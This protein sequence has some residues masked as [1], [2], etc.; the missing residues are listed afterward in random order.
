[1]QAR[2]LASVLGI[3]LGAIS[4]ARAHS[5]PAGCY[6]VIVSIEISAFRADGVTPVGALIVGCEQ[7][8]YQTRIGKEDNSSL[9][10][11]S[12]GTLTL[13]TPDGVAHTVSADVPCIGGD[14]LG[15]GCDA[16][17]DFIDSALIPYTVA[18]AD[19]HNGKITATATYTG[20]V[21]H[22]AAIDT[23]GLALSVVRST[24]V[25]SCDASTTVTT[26]SSTTTTTTIPKSSCSSLKFEAAT[27]LASAIGECDARALKFGVSVRPECL[28]SANA[29]FAKS[30]AMAE[31]RGDCLTVNDQ[32]RVQTIVDSCRGALQSV[33][34]P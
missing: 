20:G 9:C 11:F 15:A 21:V 22:E 1:M 31:R 32:D 30:W 13:T 16:A 17:R 10:A 29:S 27:Q 12:G 18:P 28:E 5:D 7:I 25:E 6:A 3:I 4:S 14:G 26:S 8:L 23:P 34:L 19:V 2:I 33:L 24:L